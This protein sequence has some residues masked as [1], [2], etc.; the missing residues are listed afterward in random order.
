MSMEEIFVVTAPGVKPYTLKELKGLGLANRAS[1]PAPGKGSPEEPGGITFYGDLEDVYRA[2]LHL[3]TASR[4][5]VRL[6]SFRATA[7][8]EL[9]KKAGRLPW[10]KY[11]AP[12]Q[13][14]ALRVTCHKSRLYHSDAVAERVLGAAGDRLGKPSPP[15]NIKTED[16]GSIAQLVV[17]RMARDIC[18]ISFDS[19]GEALHRRGYRLATAK[20]PLRETLAATILLASGWEPD[21]PLMDP[22]CGSGTIP[23]EA[24]TL[25]RRLAPGLNRYFVFMDWPEFDRLAWD[26]LLLEAK[27][28]IKPAGNDLPTILGSDRDAGAVKLA[29]ENARRAGVLEQIDFSCRAVSAVEP[30]SRQGWVVTNPPYGVRV[31]SNHDLRNL[32][33]QFGKVLRSLC[34][35]WH[36]A[37]LSSDRQLIANTGLDFEGGLALVNG[38]VAIRLVQTVIPHDE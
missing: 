32:Y 12:G 3:R 26:R 35:G 6:G 11:A 37:M 10:E 4:V 15:G 38:G 16:D 22:F 24:A 21:A 18:T 9:R 28:S 1:R 36:L 13:P 34:G 23:I 33:A 27:A 2:N 25:A 19:S 14:L 5:L 30:P 20:A 7:F 29:E 8:S 17:V 31:S